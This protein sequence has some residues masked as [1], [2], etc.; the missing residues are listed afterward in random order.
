MT[1][2]PLYWQRAQVDAALPPAKL[3][4]RPTVSY[5]LYVTGFSKTLARLVT[6]S[7]LGMAAAVGAGVYLSGPLLIVVGAVGLG[8]AAGGA[9]GAAAAATAHESYTRHLSHVE[10]VNYQEP[11][12]PAPT[13]RAFIPST[14]G[15]AT[16][17]A[18]RFQLEQP[19]WAALFAAAAG[20][21]GKLTRDNAARVLPRHLYRDWSSTAGELRRLG[22]LDDGGAVTPAGWRFYREAVGGAPLPYA[23]E[24]STGAHSTH[25]PRTPRTHGGA[26]G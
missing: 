2:Q 22:I 5:E 15:A 18:G 12:P 16:V 25:A 13:V 7:F 14:N 9:V 3:T 4:T 6:M 21:G 10:T 24:A 26:E 19:T 17:R 11:P 20:N 8:L 23:G 1:D